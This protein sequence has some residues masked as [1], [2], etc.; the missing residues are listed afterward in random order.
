MS[1]LTE[2]D[3][4]YLKDNMG[5]VPKQGELRDFLEDL[6]E[7]TAYQCPSP[8][9]LEE[10]SKEYNDYHDGGS[11]I[12][13][14]LEQE[15]EEDCGQ[16]NSSCQ[17][18]GVKSCKCLRKITVTDEYK[19][20]NDSVIN[21]ELVYDICS[22]N[23]NKNTMYVIAK[24]ETLTGV[25]DVLKVK[26]VGGRCKF[27]N[28]EYCYVDAYEDYQ[29]KIRV[30]PGGE[31]DVT[32]SNF[33]LVGSAINMF[34]PKEV[35][36]LLNVIGFLTSKSMSSKENQLVIK[37]SFCEG[38]TVSLY[39]KSVPYFKIT[40]EISGSVT[41]VIPYAGESYVNSA[42]TGEVKGVF[43]NQKIEWTESKGDVTYDRQQVSRNDGERSKLLEIFSK[44]Y[45]AIHML[46]KA[47]SSTNSSHLSTSP[48]RSSTTDVS[49]EN[50]P[51]KAAT[52]SIS[53]K[54][55]TN[56]NA[57]ELELKANQDIDSLLLSYSSINCGFGVQVTGKIDFVEM[58]VN[59]V[60]GMKEKVRELRESASNKSN[61]VNIALVCDLILSAK[62]EV[63]LNVNE[64]A[65]IT[66]FKQSSYK[67]EDNALTVESSIKL[68]GKI[69]LKAEV[70]VNQ[71]F[72][73][74]GVEASATLHT[75][76]YF[77]VRTTNN[78]ESPFQYC[79]YFEGIKFKVELVVY[80][81]SEKE[82]GRIEKRD[83]VGFEE[84]VTFDT[85]KSTNINK[86]ILYSVDEE[87]KFIPPIGR[88]DD[89]KDF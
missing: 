14:D 39:V 52:S 71:W 24:D 76:Y 21:R 41:C 18:C 73:K 47:P 61:P 34:F 3:L 30:Y 44:V 64:G 53:L 88:K 45:E 72:L 15:K 58:M 79:D 31:K 66:L 59:R 11:D 29:E 23:K 55:F 43:G 68:I 27:N 36:Y 77:K 82:K 8:E 78:K 12:L 69:L 38:E 7:A 84:H 60:P 57:G 50:D 17:T 49:T 87:V 74:G 89:W 26:V 70:G 6:R 10:M 80:A 63:K 65:E 81:G 33:F 75:A 2:D 16:V 42:I 51:E 9:K 20:S 22:E 19:V 67:G 25:E 13:E 48:T 35:C 28:Y 46:K 1:V 54:F 85:E 86:S 5:L 32:V 37:S 4:I 83:R 56:I 62:G 40:G